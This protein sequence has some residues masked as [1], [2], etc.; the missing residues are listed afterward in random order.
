MYELKVNDQFDYKVDKAGEEL[1][2]NNN[3]IQADI[4][5][6][7]P[8]TWHIIE[9]LRSYNV[10]VINFD[11][12]A[13][14]AQIRVNSN[15]YS[16]TAKDRFDVLLDQMGLSGLTSARISELKAPM[17]GLVLKVFVKSG[18]TVQKGDSLFILEAMKMENIIKS[19]VDT[20]VGSIKTKPGDKVEKGQI[21][22]QFA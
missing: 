2:I 4:K 7:S 16:I 17:P 11:K 3:K 14:T 19:P 20:V 1:L 10:E 6:L 22:L 13:K 8:S 18:D 5:Q 12:I 9:Q 15:I 21:L